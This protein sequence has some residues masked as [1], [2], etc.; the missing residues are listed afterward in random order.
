MG[1]TQPPNVKKMSTLQK[2]LS[3]FYPFLNSQLM[4]LCQISLINLDCCMKDNSMSSIF[5]SIWRSSLNWY[6]QSFWAF[7]SAGHLVL[8]AQLMV[9]GDGYSL[10]V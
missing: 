9:E 4:H 1:T 10:R 2:H 5:I 6:K 7:Y 8:M 3:D